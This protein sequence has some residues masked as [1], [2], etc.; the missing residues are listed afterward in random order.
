MQEPKFK[1]GDK[2]IFMPRRGKYTKTEWSLQGTVATIKDD[3]IVPTIMFDNIL[4][5][6]CFSG[7]TLITA[8]YEDDLVLA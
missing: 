6:E 2:V 8:A 4:K 5:A 3:D 1:R 7:K